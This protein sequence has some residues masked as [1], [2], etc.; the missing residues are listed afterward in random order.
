MLQREGPGKYISIEISIL[1]PRV[2]TNAHETMSHK[3]PDVS[4]TV[5][6]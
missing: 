1:G 5:P 6:K 4:F 2:Q 3:V